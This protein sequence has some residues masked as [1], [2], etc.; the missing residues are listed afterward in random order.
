M[1]D[2]LKPCPFCGG[3]AILL[4]SNRG[5]KYCGCL[6]CG[7]KGPDFYEAFR[8]ASAWDRRVPEPMSNVISWVRYD[9]TP[10]TTPA[11]G[12]LVL[13][14]RR[15]SRANRLFEVARFGPGRQEWIFDSAEENREAEEGDLWAYL[16]EV[17]KDAET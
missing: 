4:S 5:K 3:K 2:A 11:Y 13:L 16:P 8:V 9:E 15:K 17:P 6:I 12:A 7:C 10:E 14:L 1:N